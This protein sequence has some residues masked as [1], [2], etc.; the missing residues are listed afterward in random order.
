MSDNGFMQAYIFHA[1]VYRGTK[2]VMREGTVKAYSPSAALN[3]IDK[4]TS[5]WDKPVIHLKVFELKEG[6]E[7]GAQVSSSQE[8]VQI[9]PPKK[10][11]SY[12]NTLITS[13]TEVYERLVPPIHEIKGYYL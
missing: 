11:K 4:I 5:K 10:D 2:L 12:E 9:S 6:G 8:L 3:L 7:L 13:G 1:S